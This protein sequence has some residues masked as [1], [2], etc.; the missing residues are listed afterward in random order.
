LIGFAYLKTQQV[1]LA[2]N[3]FKSLIERY[4]QNSNHYVNL[5][6]SYIIKLNFVEAGKTMN[7]LLEVKPDAKNEDNVK[8]YLILAFFFK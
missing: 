2:I 5:A 3:Q 7:R 6:T 4:P 1:D 8:K